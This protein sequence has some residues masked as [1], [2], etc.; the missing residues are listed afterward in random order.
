MFSRNVI[1][2]EEDNSHLKKPKITNQMIIEKLNT[3]MSPEKRSKAVRKI[4]SDREN[5]ELITELDN[6][7]LQDDKPILAQVDILKKEL[8]EFVSESVKQNSSEIIEHSAQ[9]QSYFSQQEITKIRSIYKNSVFFKNSNVKPESYFLNYNVL[10]YKSKDQSD[11]YYIGHQLLKYVLT[12]YFNQHLN[13]IVEEKP[14]DKRTSLNI[15]NDEITKEFQIQE[16]LMEYFLNQRQLFYLYSRQ[17]NLYELDPFLKQIDFTSADFLDR[18]AHERLF[19]ALIG[20]I[21]MNIQSFDVMMNHI[22]YP[23]IVKEFIPSFTELI[24]NNLSQISTKR[25]FQKQMSIVEQF[26]YFHSRHYK[27]LPT[28][29]SVATA[30]DDIQM[31]QVY[32][33]N[34]QL[35]SIG[36]GKDYQTAK[37]DAARRAILHFC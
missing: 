23:F 9:P 26:E 29:T 18:T 24:Q 1:G 20:N 13:L 5:K 21:Y 32:S 3:L 25:P 6:L 33:N 15:I 7:V 22:L 12:K 30:G 28:Y 2:R 4:R 17:N 8:V 11:L 36:Y 16:H 14:E 31:V 19:K 35:L 10:V 37:E 27:S 34:N